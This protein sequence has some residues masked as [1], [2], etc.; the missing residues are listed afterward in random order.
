MRRHG[1]AKRAAGRKP[2]RRS[3]K[4]AA[5]RHATK[6]P[7]T[8][9]TTAGRSKKA[10]APQRRTAAGRSAARKST[11]GRKTAARA[12]AS[13]S[14]VS[15]SQGARSAKAKPTPKPS[16]IAAAATAIRGTFA[17]G[18]AAVTD[19][20][21][22]TARDLDAIALLEKD[23]R[24]F[25]EL[26]KRGE[27]STERAVKSRTELLDILTAELNAHELV[28]EK[29]LYPALKRHPEAKDIVL[30]GYQEHHVA[31]LI[32]KEL[33][34][35]AKNDERWGPKFK[36]LKESLEHHIQEE[37]GEMFRTARGIFSREEL[38]E[39]GAR[40]ARMKAIDH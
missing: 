38:F 36:V 24:R 40:M 34:S 10:A 21:P 5:A 14:T 9:R 3:A 33:H 12:A 37:E 39:M 25:E 30:E 1:V 35:L 15:R 28:E 11:S 8:K 26:L 23:H 13:R 16:R 7:T 32:V 22:W 31:D 2:V 20:L 29:I 4:Q 19:R 27:D 6:T 18:L 17:G